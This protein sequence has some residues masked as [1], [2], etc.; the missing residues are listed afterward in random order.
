MLLYPLHALVTLFLD[1]AFIIKGNAN[2]ERNPHSD[3]FPALMTPF[4]L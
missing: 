3:S 2:N 4:L 1:R